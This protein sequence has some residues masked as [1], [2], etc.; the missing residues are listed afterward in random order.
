[1]EEQLKKVKEILIKYKQEHLLQFYDELSSE[2]QGQLLKQILSIN[3]DE[4]LQLYEASK[5]NVLDSTEEVEPLP[6]VNKSTLSKEELSH[7]FYVGLKAIKNGELAVITLA[8]GQ[9]S[10]LGFKGPKGTFKLDTVPKMSLFEI[11]CNYLKSACLCYRV[12]IPWYIMTS[13]SNYQATIDFFKQND[14]FGYPQQDIIFFVQEDL[15]IIDT[16]GKLIL[17]EIYKVKMASNGNGNL[18]HSL[19]KHHLLEDM[20]KRNIKWV[21]IGGVDN[22]LLDPLDPIFVG[23]TVDSKNLVA[24]KSLFKK[25]PDSLDWVFARKYGKPAIVDC[26]NFVSQMSK[27]QDANG[28]YLYRETNMLAHIFSLDALS[29]LATV[30]L[31][32]HRAFRKSAFVNY[33]GM[34]QVPDRPNIYKFEQFVFD[35]FS[36]FDML[37]LLSVN[38]SE[39]FAPI[40]DFNGP[41]NPEVAK[42]L[43]EKN[44]LHC[45]TNDET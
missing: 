16:T 25:N 35:A 6:F 44:V 10:R 3:F 27:I 39:E 7:Y 28:N 5:F 11:I 4:I 34:K 37:T 38:P 8:G 19:H 29:S 2:Q 9:G 26:E 24:S 22:V 1:M 21:F 32:Y 42:K 43:Y 12:T 31:P 14:F 41:Y 40:K 23:L 20:R 45:A 13:S 18:F 36:E 33:E 17:E 30:K 15:P